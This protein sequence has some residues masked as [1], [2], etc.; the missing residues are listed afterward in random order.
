M[1][2]NAMHKRQAAPHQPQDLVTLR[3]SWPQDLKGQ[4]PLPV[5]PGTPLAPTL[6]NP[7]LLDTCTV[8]WAPVQAAAHNSSGDIDYFY[9]S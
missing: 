2:L 3:S 5:T 9:Q 8:P 1:W 6:P 4:W 7:A